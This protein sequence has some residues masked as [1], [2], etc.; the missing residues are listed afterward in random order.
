MRSQTSLGAC[1]HVLLRSKSSTSLH[2]AGGDCTGPE[3]AGGLSGGGSVQG[4]CSSGDS[5]RGNP[6]PDATHPQRP[7]AATQHVCTCLELCGCCS[8]DHL[9]WQPVNSCLARTAAPASGSARLRQ[10]PGTCVPLPWWPCSMQCVLLAAIYC[11]HVS[12]RLR[13]QALPPSC[14]C[15]MPDLIW[16]GQ[17]DISACLSGHSTRV[18]QFL[19]H[20]SLSHLSLRCLTGH[21]LLHFCRHPGVLRA[22]EPTNKEGAAVSCL[23]FSNQVRQ[24]DCLQTHLA[25]LHQCNAF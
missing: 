3:D 23:A 12:R 4:S 25:G 11:S 19:S 9:L 15:Q 20:F 16:Q 10:L 1:S 7:R 18:R 22:G 14:F 24:L 2:G 21:L 17:H 5:Q 8:K 6:H 13:Q